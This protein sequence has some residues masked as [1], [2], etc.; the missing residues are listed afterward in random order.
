MWLLSRFRRIEEKINIRF[1]TDVDIFNLPEGID[2]KISALYG[3]TLKEEK[4]KV[5][6]VY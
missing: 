6:N 3:L 5:K 1:A 4:Q 2:Q